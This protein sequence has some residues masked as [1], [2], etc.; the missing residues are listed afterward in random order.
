MTSV[1]RSSVPLAALGI[2]GVLAACDDTRPSG[3]TEAIGNSVAYGIWTPG[4]NDTCTPEIHNRYAVIGPDAKLYPTWHPPVDPETGCSFG[5]EHGR[6]PSGSSLFASVGPIPFGYANEQ[7]E[8]WDPAGVRREDHVGH[9]VEWEN[10]IRLHFGGSVAGAL[11]ELRCDVLTKL[12]QGTHSKDAF[13]N[14]LH[15]LV[16]HIRCD[17][18]TQMH[19][20]LMTAI[21]TPGEFVRS[22]DHDVTV[23]AGPPTPAN[24]PEGDGRRVIPDRFCVE[25]HAFG[26][27]AESVDFHEAFHESW[28][29]S[30]VVRTAEGRGIAFF[31]PYFQVDFPSRYFD[32]AQTDNV[33]RPIA[34]C[35][36]TLPNGFQ[37]RGEPCDESTAGW[38]LAGLTYDDPRSIFDGASRTVDINYNEIRNEDGPQ[39]WYTD[40]FG[41]NGRTEPFPGSVRQFVAKMN[42]DRGI[43]MGGPRLGDDRPYRGQ[44]VHPPN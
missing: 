19:V 17:D 41:Q 14:N 31:N 3:P 18:G 1:L 6:D 8:T 4:P 42:N 26:P 5:H 9:K 32:A 10:D 33:G 34:V 39:V 25:Q 37:A 12:H 7:L 21:G 20:T 35:Y 36:E 40:P 16:Y 11:L 2:I 43:G 28:E 30:N 29:T 24:S 44:G 23:V 13:T 27:D 22:C 38:T 15:E